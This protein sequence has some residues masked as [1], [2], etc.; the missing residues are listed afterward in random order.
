MW[1]ASPTPGSSTRP[2]RTR[3]PQ[4][5]S[6]EGAREALL[7]S[8]LEWTM[9]RNGIYADLTAQAL[10]QSIAAGRHVYNSGDGKTSYVARADC[11]AAAAVVLSGDGHANQAYDITGPE[12]LLRRRPGGDRER[13]ERHARRGRSGRRR[14]LRRHPRRA[15]RPARARRAVH[16]LVRAGGPRGSTVDGVER[17]RGADGQPAATLPRR[18]SRPFYEGESVPAGSVSVHAGGFEDRGIPV[19]RKTPYARAGRAGA[20]CSTRTGGSWTSCS[21]GTCGFDGV[22]VTEHGQTSYDMMPNPNLPAAVLANAIR[23][24]ARD[25]ADRAWAIARQDPRAAPHRRG[26]RDAGRA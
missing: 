22:A 24:S 13:G 20:A 6:T 19:G 26:V 10:T 23:R 9:L 12:A 25:G 1:A 14:D 17:G 8:G 3:Q 18:T 16:R 5:P 21:P 11:A 2:R 15:R 7:A 4:R